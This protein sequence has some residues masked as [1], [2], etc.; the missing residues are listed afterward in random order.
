MPAK[1]RGPVAV[2]AAAV[3]AAVSLAVAGYTGSAASA[4]PVVRAQRTGS[5]SG[6]GQL[7]GLLPRDHLT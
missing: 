7:S 1:K 3:A 2:L 6:L 4:A 5:A